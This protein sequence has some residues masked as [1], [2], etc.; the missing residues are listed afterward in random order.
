MQIILSKK[1]G[2]SIIYNTDLK[3]Y[4]RFTRRIEIQKVLED[5]IKDI[6]FITPFSNNIT[7]VGQIGDVM[8][9]FYELHSNK[10]Y[11]E[12]MQF[13][14]GFNGYIDNVYSLH[15]Q[16]HAS[17]ECAVSLI[18]KRHLRMLSATLQ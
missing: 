3:T 18:I 15:L 8:K 11:N 13:S 9:V 12:A 6:K 17:R 1:N 7:K 5:F 16:N 10:N 2:L 4:E 14:F